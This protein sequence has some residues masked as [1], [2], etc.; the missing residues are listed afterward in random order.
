MT[1]PELI[2]RLESLFDEME[3]NRSWGAIEIEYRDGEANMIRTTKNEK[4]N[5]T[6]ENT[7]VARKRH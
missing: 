1:R 3:R 4:L 2:R 5:G 7:R 6:Q